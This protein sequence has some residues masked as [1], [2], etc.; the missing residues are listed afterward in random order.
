MKND[1]KRQT[2]YYSSGKKV[3]LKPAPG[4]FAINDKEVGEKLSVASYLSSIRSVLKNLR[5][6]LAL[7]DKNDLNEDILEKL[8]ELKI[9]YPVFEADG[10]LVIPLPE[11]RIED[12]DQS[13][14]IDVRN[15]VREH[16]Q[17][18]KIISDKHGRIS[19]KPVSNDPS[20]ALEIANRV[21]EEIGP[22]LAQTRFIR[23]ISRGASHP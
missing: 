13:R 8:R 6:H 20:D 2:Y 10:A 21:T 1:S 14:L 22:D 12:D 11:V 18:A 3:P 4:L 15:W 5:G 23:K 16:S 7:I 19:V 9:V 17:L